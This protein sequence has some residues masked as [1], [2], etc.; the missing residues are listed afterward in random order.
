MYDIVDVEVGEVDFITETDT[1]D[2]FTG[3]PIRGMMTAKEESLLQMQG[4]SD[5]A[6]AQLIYL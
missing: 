1:I 2:F 5:T 6:A 4:S 3:L